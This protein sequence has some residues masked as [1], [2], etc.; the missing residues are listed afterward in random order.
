MTTELAISI[1][2]I[3]LSILSFGLSFYVALRDRPRLKTE[4]QAYRHQETGE[5]YSFYLKAVNSGRRPIVLTLI[6]GQHEGN[7]KCGTFIDYENRGVKLEEGEFYE[8]RFGKFDGIMVCDPHDQG[9][10]FDL[11]DLSI[12]DSA[13]K[14]YRVRN[15]K[16]NIQLLRRSKHPMGIR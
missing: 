8:Y 1:V 5:Y 13:D 2:A 10:L 12:V 16:E 11:V 6:E 9:D 14:K 15:A 3:T 7:H 4:S